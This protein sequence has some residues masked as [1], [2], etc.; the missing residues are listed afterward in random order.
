MSPAVAVL[1][2]LGGIALLAA[3]GDLLVRG[4]VSLARLL[5]VSTAVIGLTVVAMGTSTPELAVSLL[6]ALQG[7]SDIAVANVVGSNIFNV[8]AILGVSALVVPLVV[9]MTAVR[10]EWPVMAIVSLQFLLLARDGALDRLEGA[11]FLVALVAFTAYM[12][13]LARRDLSAADADT[14][15]ASV[16]SWTVR[17][18][19]LA[20]DLG[21]VIGGLL[22]LV[23]GAQLLVR[24]ATTLALAAGVSERVVGLTIVAAGTSMP[25]LAASLVA[26]WRKQADIALANVIGSNIFNI[27]GILGVVALITPQRVHPVIVASDVWWMVGIALLLFPVMRSGMRIGRREGALLLAVYGV[28]LVMLAA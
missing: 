19:R 21:L 14:I 15:A 11:F 9:H 6:A 10:L 13:H 20:L 12:V 16:E 25:E 17:G 27:A 7:K 2:I 26:A 1:L 24:G 18:R 23:A 4:A 8:V 5:R 28:Y 22:I 3:G